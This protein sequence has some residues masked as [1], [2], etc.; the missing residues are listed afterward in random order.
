[1]KHNLYDIIEAIWFILSIIVI[2]MAVSLI[3]VVMMGL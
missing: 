3:G 2:S 1:M